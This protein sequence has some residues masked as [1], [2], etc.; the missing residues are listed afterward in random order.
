MVPPADPVLDTVSFTSLYAVVK[1]KVRRVQ[2]LEKGWESG[3]EQVK[4][5]L[6]DILKHSLGP[7][8][9]VRVLDFFGK[10]DF[11]TRLE[12]V[13]T[14]S[15]LSEYAYA[16]LGSYLNLIQQ[17]SV[18]VENGGLSADKEK[19]ARAAV[20]LAET[21]DFGRI[22]AMVDVY[23]ELG[24]RLEDLSRRLEP[25]LVR[26]VRERVEAR[27]LFIAGQGV[28]LYKG[29]GL[30]LEPLRKGIECPLNSVL[31][32]YAQG[33]WFDEAC[34]ALDLYKEAGLS[35]ADSSE[36]T[37]G[38]IVEALV[39]KIQ[40]GDVYVL[41][42]GHRL[43][44]RLGLSLENF[45]HELKAPLVTGVQGFVNKRE[46]SAARKVALFYQKLRLPVVELGLM[47]KEPLLRALEMARHDYDVHDGRR[48]IPPSGKGA[49]AKNDLFS[50]AQGIRMYTELGLPLPDLETAVP[51]Y[52]SRM[53]RSKA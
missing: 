17:G 13:M 30:S 20:D 2:G 39:D 16:K 4:F 47:V 31:R 27:D 19:A 36:T 52:L 26:A 12:A 9:V 53:G 33:G 10:P 40:S 25:L 49:I 14:E 1:R 41:D 6:G 34:E 51:D 28:D 7:D 45:A 23:Q 42:E 46:L 38:L 37:G 44:Q 18:R 48:D 32:E 29:L 24:F 15:D 8:Q 35:S 22:H 5:A 11:R 50:L 21:G 43:Y 3:F